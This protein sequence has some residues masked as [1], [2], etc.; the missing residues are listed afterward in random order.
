MAKSITEYLSIQ[1]IKPEFIRKTGH[2][3]PMVATFLDSQFHS[4]KRY[5][6]QFYDKTPASKN[7]KSN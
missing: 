3:E 7:E 1:L 5:I 4:D 6:N 2:K